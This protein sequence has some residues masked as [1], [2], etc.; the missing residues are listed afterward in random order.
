MEYTWRWFGPNDTVSLWDARQAG[1][2]GIVTALHHIPTGKI[3]EKEEIAKR[4]LEIEK[5]GTYW[6]VAESIPVHENIKTR[7]GQYKTYIENYKRSLLNLGA[8][9]VDTVC[10]NFM[11]VLDATRTDFSFALANGA[12]ALLFDTVA[13]AAFELF[14]LK[15]PGAEAAYSEDQKLKA[16]AYL[17]QLSKAQ[18]EKLIA[19]IVAGF[20][21]ISADYTLPQFQ[22]LLDTYQDIGAT[23]LKENLQHFLKEILPAAE[24]A[25]IRMAI[26]PD[27]PPFPVL[28]LPRVVSTEADVKEL[29]EAVDHPNNGLC[30][31][32]GSF[33]AR[34]DNDLAGMVKRWGTKIHFVHLRSTK[35]ISRE[36][37][38]ESEHL[39]GDVDMF[40]VIQA[41]VEEQEKRKLA[42]R[43]DTRMP[44]RSDHGH[45]MLDDLNKKTVP[46]YSA[47]GRLKGLAEIR[48][49]EMAIRRAGFPTSIV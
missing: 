41:L 36:S 40:T 10:Y 26:H 1:A 43:K 32:T 12:T 20:P 34:P 35:W 6:S 29:F 11:P 45:Q 2:T 47:I 23:D 19:T 15:R 28:G 16:E 44:M 17:R 8:A 24:E 13:L 39:S 4:K 42:K 27:D 38:I 49:V 30:F 14:L 18:E 46:G 3:W 22:S 21:G 33:G 5:A 25:G 7:S 37:F 31:C 48:G 9:G